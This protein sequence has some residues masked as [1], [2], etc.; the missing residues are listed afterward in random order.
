M[1]HHPKWIDETMGFGWAGVDLFFVLSGYLISTPLFR[2]MAQAKPISVPDFFIKRI[3]RIIPLYLV[4]LSIYFMIPAFREKEALPPLW[5]FLTFTQNFGFDIKNYGTF[6][7]VWSLCVEEHFYLLFPWVIAA[8]IY[9]KAWKKGWIL[10]LLL[11]VL[12]L[13]VRI[14]GWHFL[15]APHKDQS[16]FGII[17]YRLI[18]YPTYNRL[19]GL[20]AGIA[21][22][23][24]FT[25][26]PA[27]K[28]RL[29][30]NG[31][32]ILILGMLVLVGAWFL[33]KD[34]K[35]FYA[36]VFGFPLVSAGFG[37]LV[38]SAIC[39]SC[40]LYR[41]NSRA[42]TLIAKLS[43]A[44]Y[45]SHKG[46]IHLIQPQIAKTGIDPKGTLMLLLCF[47]TA[48]LGAY[49]LNKAIE[50]PFLRLRAIILEHR[51]K[52]QNP[53]NV[54]TIVRSKTRATEKC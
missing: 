17:W 45:L 1:F 26:K 10:I 3:F 52:R 44:L 54:Q 49:M 5:K 19:D 16:D 37:L 39:P 35:S 23:A 8:L 13:V 15:I 25:F 28:G 4:L 42:T 32:S 11:F 33:C 47:I 29:S 40:V 46:V 7:H 27:I 2:R 41:F 12:G 21:I 18:Y 43:Y 34:Q 31:N 22:G 53:G 20:L 24:L 36:T 38:M 48:L 14:A 6:S 50:T 9:G 51:K 30:K